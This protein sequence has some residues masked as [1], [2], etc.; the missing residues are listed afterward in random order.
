MQGVYPDPGALDVV[1]SAQ[2]E[3][4][5]NAEADTTTCTNESLLL[6]AIGEDGTILFR[7]EYT[8]EVSSGSNKIIFSHDTALP[9]GWEYALVVETD[10]ELVCTD[11]EGRPLDPFG[12]QFY[13]P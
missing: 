10:G 5:V 1:V 6:A 2:P 11:T 4:R 3:L 8:I 12:S 13:V 7:P 9:S